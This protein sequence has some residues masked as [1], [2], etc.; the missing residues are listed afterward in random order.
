MQELAAACPEACAVKDSAGDLPLHLAVNEAVDESALIILRAHND[1]VKETGATGDT[2]LHCAVKRGASAE[3]VQELA[4][5][6]PE[7]CLV[8]NLKNQLA[9]DWA[10]SE[11][12]PPAVVQELAIAC[13][14]ACRSPNT[15]GDLPL[16]VAVKSS[17]DKETV[18]ALLGADGGA[19]G[20]RDKAGKSTLELAVTLPAV[21]PEILQAMLDHFPEACSMPNAAQD[22]PIH[23][24]LAVEASE[25]DLKVQIDRLDRLYHA[26]PKTLDGVKD[27]SGRIARTIAE[28]HASVEIHEWVKKCGALLGRYRVVRSVH[29]SATCLVL[30]VLDEMQDA[31]EL[32]LKLM[33]NRIQF[34]CE[35]T[36]RFVGGHALDSAHV[37]GIVG[38]HTPSTAPFS[39]ATGKP[40]EAESTDSMPP[41]KSEYAF[42]LAM[43]LATADLAT[44]IMHGH[45]AGRDYAHVKSLGGSIAESFHYLETQKLCHCDVK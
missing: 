21:S 13:P 20:E 31:R 44:D 14:A 38:W 2:V 37:V 6:C 24:V 11:S 34:E 10:L 4:A 7:A 28:A 41:D 30:I 32:V 22:L 8:A 9:L 45:Y 27:G 5:A 40:Q 23:V 16:H 15:S 35:I 3:L 1:A 18:V 12:A 42:A 19:V 29:M 33:K 17:K 36:S 26:Q 39:D 43:E 25:D